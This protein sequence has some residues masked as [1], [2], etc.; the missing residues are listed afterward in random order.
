MFQISSSSQKS[1]RW[2]GDLTVNIKPK[3]AP[4]VRADPES[5]RGRRCGAASPASSRV[6]GSDRRVTGPIAA[7]AVTSHTYRLPGRPSAR[8]PGTVP[9]L[10]DSESEVPKPCQPFRNP[11]TAARRRRA[12][13]RSDQSRRR[14]LSALRTVSGFLASQVLYH[15]D[16]PR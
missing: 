11:V 14:A 6:P 9:R 13:A 4:V 10:S 8:G 16:D 7:L 12:A 3:N 1:R 2:L 5:G 15:R